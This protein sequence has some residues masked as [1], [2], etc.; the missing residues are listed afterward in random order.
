MYQIRQLNKSS[1]IFEVE[2]HCYPLKVKAQ[3]N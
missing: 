3:N 1:P 2:C